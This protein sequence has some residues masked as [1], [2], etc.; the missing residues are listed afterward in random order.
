MGFGGGG[1]GYLKSVISG[2]KSEGKIWG[3]KLGG[4]GPEGYL[5]GTI[6]G[7]L[8]D[9]RSEIRDGCLF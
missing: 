3:G 5:R 7:Q 1:G 6:W 4:E 2:V 9:Q 8:R